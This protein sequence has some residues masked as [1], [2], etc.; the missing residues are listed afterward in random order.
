MEESSIQ[1]DLIDRFVALTGQYPYAL[2]NPTNITDAVVLPLTANNSFTTA[3]SLTAMTAMSSSQ[4]FDK[5]V[6]LVLKQV[7]NYLYL[8]FT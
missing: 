3:E 4:D 6:D 1:T 7:R 2:R 5:E 8:H